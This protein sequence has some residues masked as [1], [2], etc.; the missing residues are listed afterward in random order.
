MLCKVNY[1]REWFHPREQAFGHG[2]C[3]DSLAVNDKFSLCSLT[4]W[5]IDKP[6]P[7]LWDSRLAGWYFDYSPPIQ[8]EQQHPSGKFMRRVG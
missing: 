3:F 2:V 5:F 7:R 8:S 1:Q 4:P 6:V